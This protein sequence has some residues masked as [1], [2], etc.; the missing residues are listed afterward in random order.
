MADILF[1]FIRAEAGC[2]LGAKGCLLEEENGE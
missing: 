2:E 1:L